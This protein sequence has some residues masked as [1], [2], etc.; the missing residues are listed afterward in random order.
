MLSISVSFIVSA[1]LLFVFAQGL[2]RTALALSQGDIKV[3]VLTQ[4]CVAG[5]AIVLLLIHEGLQLPIGADE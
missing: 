4:I 3:A 1:A 5:L 2:L